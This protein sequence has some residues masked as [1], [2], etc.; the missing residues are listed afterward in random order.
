MTEKNNILLTLLLIQSRFIFLRIHPPWLFVDVIF[1]I[2]AETGVSLL[3]VVCMVQCPELVDF[4]T[5]P[6]HLLVR[7]IDGSSSYQHQPVV[8]F[9]SSPIL[10][11]PRFRR[12][13]HFSS[14]LFPDHPR[15]PVVAVPF[16]TR[17]VPS[18]RSVA[19]FCCLLTRVRRLLERI[20]DLV[21][22]SAHRNTT[23]V[24]LFSYSARPV[25]PFPAGL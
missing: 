2:I 1:V 20:L 22:L 14:L 17:Y 6:L 4:C 21:L 3:S 13:F 18:R 25:L 24:C 5:R 9:V 23:T 12:R 15:L 10:V 8:V 16:L 7:T 19:V 11:P